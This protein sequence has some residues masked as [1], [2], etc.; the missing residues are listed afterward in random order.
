MAV[1]GLHVYAAASGAAFFV[2]AKAFLHDVGVR[3][4]PD[5]LIMLALDIGINVLGD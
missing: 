4:V 1:I 3:F 5:L 2:P